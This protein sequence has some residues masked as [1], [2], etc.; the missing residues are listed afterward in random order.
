[1]TQPILVPVDG[2]E[3]SERALAP[4][5]IL[6]RAQAAELILA[7]VLEP[8]VWMLTGPEGYTSA[9]VYQDLFDTL[10]QDARESLERVVAGLSGQGVQAS[11]M[12]LNGT[13]AASLLDLEESTHPGLVVMASHGRGGLARF[14]LGSVADR[15]VRHGTVPVLVVRAFTAPVAQL[16]TALVPLDGSPTAEAALP[17]VEKLAGKPLRAVRL[18]RAIGFH[19]DAAE[20]RNYLSAIANRLAGAGLDTSVDVRV[21]EPARA[22][23]EAADGVDLVILATH[24]RGGLDRLRHGSVAEAALRDLPRPVLLVRAAAVVRAEVP[25]TGLAQEGVP[26]MDEAKQQPVGLSLGGRVASLAP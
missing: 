2:S 23:A 10:E 22:I 19:E 8:Q 26:A 20:A 1:M 17:M 3:L 9:D 5:A 4:A 24:G 16:D 7:R 18:L 12:V 6:A 21:A 11:S 15:M 14:A 13:A 25:S